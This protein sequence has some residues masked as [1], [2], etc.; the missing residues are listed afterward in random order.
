MLCRSGASK[1]VAATVR[2]GKITTDRMRQ[3]LFG[4]FPRTVGVELKPK[5]AFTRVRSER[6]GE[7]T[8]WVE[9]GP[10]YRI[11]REGLANERRQPHRFAG[12]SRNYWRRTLMS[13]R[14]APY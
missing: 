7:R 5:T 13:S 11:L 3:S 10:S 12:S 2:D 1:Q 14:S 8:K 4:D 6:H 9:R